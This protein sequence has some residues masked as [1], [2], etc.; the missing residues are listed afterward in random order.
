[1]L[2]PHLLCHLPEPAQIRLQHARPNT[3]H[4][5][6]VRLQ[7]VV[8]IQHQHIQCRLAATISDSFEVELGLGPARGLGWRGKVLLTSLVDGGEAGDEDEARVGGLEEKGDEGV[9]QNVRASDVDVVG[10]GEA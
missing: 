6:P 4:L 1:M 5:D 10:F 7:L 2:Q 3:P 9:G 8:P